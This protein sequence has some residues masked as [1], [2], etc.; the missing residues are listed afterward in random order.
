[1]S[2]DARALDEWKA[3]VPAAQLAARYPAPVL[4]A[5]G[6]HLLERNYAVYSNP[7][8]PDHAALSDEIKTLMQAGNPGFVGPGGEISDGPAP[9]GLFGGGA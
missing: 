9:A 7:R 5:L 1:M 2:G 8:H 3:G 6:E 4:A